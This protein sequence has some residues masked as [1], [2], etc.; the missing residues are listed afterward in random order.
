MGDNAFMKNIFYA[1]FASVALVVLC[2]CSSTQEMK[3]GISFADI[4]TF[5]VDQPTGADSVLYSVGSREPLD[6][7]VVA[8]I[9]EK[10]KAEG[11]VPAADRQS[12]QMIIRPQWNTVLRS[13]RE[14]SNLFTSRTLSIGQDNFGA[15]CMLEIQI[16]F[17][18]RDDWVWRGFG[19]QELT[20]SNLNEGTIAN[21]VYWCLSEFPPEK[22]PDVLSKLREERKRKAEAEANPFAHIKVEKPQQPAASNADSSANAQKDKAQGAK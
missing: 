4:K 17:P 12:A 2:A 10:L 15:Y 11:Y 5:Y 13:E 16:Y 20:S 1:F 9:S 7:V 6:A 19:P 21:Q 8:K 22:Y 14:P 18:N 3:E